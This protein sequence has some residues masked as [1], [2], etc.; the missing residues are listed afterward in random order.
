MSKKTERKRTFFSGL[1]VMPT[2][3]IVLGVFGEDEGIVGSP[4][5]RARR[6][7]ERPHRGRGP[8]ANPVRNPKSAI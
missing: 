4:S 6:G 7:H 3:E 2:W 8:A 5:E 1:L